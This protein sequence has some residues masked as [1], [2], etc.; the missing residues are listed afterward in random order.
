LPYNY[1]YSYSGATITCS[2]LP[3]LKEGADL[4]VIKT[5]LNDLSTFVGISIPFPDIYYTT[6]IYIMLFILLIV[7]VVMRFR[8]STS[9]NKINPNAAIGEPTGG[10]YGDDISSLMTYGGGYDSDY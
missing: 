2:T 6:Y 8:I 7:L 4:A 5:Q 1:P 9:N 10:M 3:V